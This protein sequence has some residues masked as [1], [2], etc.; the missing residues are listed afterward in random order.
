MRAD[1]RAD[2]ALHLGG[3]QAVPPAVELPGHE[4]TESRQPADLG[5]V[6]VRVHVEDHLVARLSV[7]QRGDEVTHGPAQDEQRRFLADLVG[8][9]RLEPAR[10]RILAV[11][12][13]A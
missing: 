10:G 13:V 11:L 2:R 1:R 8:R 4:P 3:I 6:T 5:I 12:V 9:E 7:C